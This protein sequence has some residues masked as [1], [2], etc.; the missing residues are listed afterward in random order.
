MPGGGDVQAGCLSA[1]PFSSPL[2]WPTRGAPLLSPRNLLPSRSRAGALP[3]PVEQPLNYSPAR[4]LAQQ[5]VPLRGA[6]HTPPGTVASG[7]AS[8]LGH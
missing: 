1:W 7:R 8:P 4:R 2:G 5:K 3:L 6:L